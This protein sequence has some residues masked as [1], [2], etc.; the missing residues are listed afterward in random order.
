MRE[1]RVQRVTVPSE[2]IEE[3]FRGDRMIIEGV[4]DDAD[5]VRTYDDP[6]RM[7]FNFIFESEEFPVV[8]EGGEMPELEIAA[9]KRRCNVKDYIVCPTCHETINN[10]D[11]R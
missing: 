7:T 5:L 6:A 10:G 3:Y 11:V 4:P 2:S 1:R 9:V 8:E